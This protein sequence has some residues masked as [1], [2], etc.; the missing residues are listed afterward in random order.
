MPLNVHKLNETQFFEQ[1]S[2][3]FLVFIVK[4]RWRYQR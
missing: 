3:I 2:L 1:K 4:N